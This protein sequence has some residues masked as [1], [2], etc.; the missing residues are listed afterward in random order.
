MS[1]CT[2]A[3]SFL[4]RCK[5][6]LEVML[7]M[8]KAVA[9]HIPTATN[10]ND[11]IRLSSACSVSK[12]VQDRTI[13]SHGRCSHYQSAPC[14][15]RLQ[16]VGRSAMQSESPLAVCPENLQLQSFRQKSSIKNVRNR[17]L[18]NVRTDLSHL[19]R[20]RRKGQWLCSFAFSW[21]RH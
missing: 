20:E 16:P 7:M 4:L 9:S 17:L 13:H 3:A 5:Y 21:P 8:A 2:M 14:D 1:R 11:L 6:S 12:R 19:D 10:R 15:C 18:R